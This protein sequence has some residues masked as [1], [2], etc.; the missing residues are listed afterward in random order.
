[1][2]YLAAFS[3]MLIA[4]S[5]VLA[6]DNSN[7]NLVGKW[8]AEAH[9]GD[10]ITY[11]FKKD[12][13]VDWIVDAKASQGGI[14]K[15]KYKIDTSKDPITVDMFDFDLEQ[16]K[17]FKFLGIISVKDKDTILM[18]GK[19][20]PKTS[21]SHR[22]KEFSSQALEFKRETSSG[23]NKQALTASQIKYT[24]SLLKGTSAKTVLNKLGIPWVWGETSRDPSTKYFDFSL[25]WN[26]NGKLGPLDFVK[27]DSKQ[28]TWLYLK[29]G[30]KNPHL[31]DSC[32][33]L[34]FTNNKL[35]KVIIGAL[36]NIERE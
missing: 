5:S 33:V 29:P 17:Q 28:V 21:S 16:L 26:V 30:Y 19:P 8:F 25:D 7:F 34:F 3:L 36:G 9:N 18:E 23:N 12:G 11:I 1:M 27:T 2:K 20:S 31:K 13:D 24:A 35:D 14:I 6:G 10:K 4:Y 22:P 32:V 15:A